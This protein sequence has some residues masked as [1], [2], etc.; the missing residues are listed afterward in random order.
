MHN[1]GSFDLTPYMKTN[2]G[3]VGNNTG[4]QAAIPLQTQN[5]LPNQYSELDNQGLHNIIAGSQLVFYE[6]TSYVNDSMASSI[7]YVNFVQMAP[8]L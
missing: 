6:R 3:V 8:L 1:L 2:P 7:T 4:M 5:N